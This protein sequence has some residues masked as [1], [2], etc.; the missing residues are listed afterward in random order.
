MG[1]H[2]NS[3]TGEYDQEDV[4]SMITAAM[5]RCLLDNTPHTRAEG[6]ANLA[7]G[8]DKPSK[9]YMAEDEGQAANLEEKLPETITMTRDD[10]SKLA[11]QIAEEIIAKRDGAPGP[12]KSRPPRKIKSIKGWNC[13][14]CFHSG[15]SLMSTESCPNCYHQRCSFCVVFKMKGIS[16][17]DE[18][19]EEPAN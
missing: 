2:I 16:E 17:E 3:E 6:N 11:T 7:E 8:S 10:L 19:D 13:C 5:G 1:M 9:D 14:D 12:P 15:M 4:F 18:E